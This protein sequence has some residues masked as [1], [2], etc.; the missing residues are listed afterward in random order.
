MVKIEKESDIELLNSSHYLIKK[1]LQN[2]FNLICKNYDCTDLSKVGAIFYLCRYD[3][4][5]RFSEIGLTLPYDETVYETSDLITLNDGKS[6]FTIFQVV[7][8]LNNDMAITV[9]FDMNILDDLTKSWLLEDCTERT[10]Y[11]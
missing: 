3:D 2:Q 1:H 9:V 8:L 11:L 4:I 5:K 10:V 6:K 7:Y